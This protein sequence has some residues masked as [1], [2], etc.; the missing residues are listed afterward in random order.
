MFIVE[1][2]IKYIDWKKKMF[3]YYRKVGTVRNLGGRVIREEGSH[4][5]QESGSGSSL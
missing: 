2:K 1:K 3:N 4:W 5:V